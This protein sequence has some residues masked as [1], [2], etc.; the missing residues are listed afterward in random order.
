LK[1]PSAEAEGEGARSLEGAAEGAPL[2]PV[3]SSFALGP[4]RRKPQQ[5]KGQGRRGRPGEPA[6]WRAGGE[7][8]RVG[9]VARC[10]PAAPVTGVWEVLHAC[11]AAGRWSHAECILCFL[12][13]P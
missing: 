4:G 7:S 6:R 12:R 1:P 2:P 3:A 10:Y 11:T 13:G 9:E 5:G 8:A